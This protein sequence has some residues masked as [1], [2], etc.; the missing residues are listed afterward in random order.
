MKNLFK[1]FIFAFAL[2]GQVFAQDVYIPG[3][4]VTI[5]TQ[6][7]LKDV[8]IENN[9]DETEPE[10]DSLSYSI[11]GKLRDSLKAPYN[12]DWR[13]GNKV[14]DDLDG[15][16]DGAIN[17]YT[18]ITNLNR[19]WNALG[20][21]T[22]PEEKT[23]RLLA[24]TA[25]TTPGESSATPP[26]E[27]FIEPVAQ[28]LGY[29]FRINKKR[30]INTGTDGYD[31]TLTFV[32]TGETS[33]DA[34]AP[35]NSGGQGIKLATPVQNTGAN[36]AISIDPGY[37][38][39]G[40]AN[41]FT[42]MAWVR[43]GGNGESVDNSASRI[44]SDTYTSKGNV[45][46]DLRFAGISGDN[47]GA[48]QLRVN[49]TI[50]GYASESDGGFRTG[51]KPSDN[52]WYHITVF[53]DGR[54][55]IDSW[56]KIGCFVG[57]NV[58][59]MV[60]KIDEETGESVIDESTNEPVY[61]EKKYVNFKC[62]TG[63]GGNKPTGSVGVNNISLYIGNSG[64][65]NTDDGNLNGYLDDIMIFKNWTPWDSAATTNVIT[66]TV[67]KYWAELDDTQIDPGDNEYD[68]EQLGIMNPDTYL[69]SASGLDEKLQ[70]YTLGHYLPLDADGFGNWTAITHGKRTEGF[71]NGLYSVSIGSDAIGDK[72]LN[73]DEILY[74]KL[75]NGNKKKISGTK[76][77]VDNNEV[78]YNLIALDSQATYSE[79]IISI[80]S[81]VDIGKN[82]E[83][84]DTVE[85]Y[86]TS[87]LTG[88]YIDGLVTETKTG[89]KLKTIKINVRAMGAHNN[90]STAIGNSCLAMGDYS[91]ALGCYSAAFGIGSHVEGDNCFAYNTNAVAMGRYTTANGPYAKAEGDNCYA[92]GTNSYAAGSY[93]TAIGPYTRAI[94]HYTIATNSY[95]EA[96][97]RASKAIHNYAYV[98]SS[99]DGFNP[100]NPTYYESH[101]EGTF[102][103][104]PTDGLDGF[105]IGTN[106]LADYIDARIRAA[107]ID[108]TANTD[109]S[110]N[111]EP[112]NSNRSANP[113]S[114]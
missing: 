100:N 107:F 98:W 104:D 20:L 51:I 62:Y 69:Y 40:G 64:G 61:E 54:T 34:S 48:L 57:T 108:A 45:G 13:D 76:T 90:Y 43:R 18:S 11:Y 102:N 79:N 97:G 47:A 91:I 70:D 103:I 89:G 81:T 112:Q 58:T 4:T 41:R 77:I 86:T 50:V 7:G 109:W 93:S 105:Y 95:S 12:K 49:G 14:L 17:L 113:I 8:Y 33:E 32:G 96:A 30:L 80:K 65:S 82:Y 35:L 37:N 101:D 6:T 67:I 74:I 111:R 22:K 68:T 73:G 15:S 3:D 24:E 56:K 52:N 83:I 36:A 60:A 78:Y 85:I 38:P 1:S 23:K 31:G 66:N 10:P 99:G 94:G 39:L 106:R 75:K 42:I 55:G 87:T 53:W 44:V 72:T 88:D 25:G 28:Y 29:T 63:G 114:W 46:F 21:Y 71:G 9:S 19:L 2:V 16:V 27:N 26:Y 5:A 92:E 110:G 59:E 84:G